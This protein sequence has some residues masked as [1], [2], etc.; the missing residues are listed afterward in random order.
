MIL[1][2]T[3]RVL[4][5]TRGS[6]DA[7]VRVPHNKGVTICHQADS[8]PGMYTYHKGTRQSLELQIESSPY[9]PSKEIR[10]PQ[11]PCGDDLLFHEPRVDGHW[12]AESGE[13]EMTPDCLAAQSLAQ[14]T[15]RAAA[16][17]CGTVRLLIQRLSSKLKAGTT[18]TLRRHWP[19]ETGH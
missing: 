6:L 11:R 18:A 7:V 9:S 3:L 4:N 12:Q 15:A 1:Q 2:A 19:L 8:N 17:F 5:K 14:S 16:S 13:A 10:A